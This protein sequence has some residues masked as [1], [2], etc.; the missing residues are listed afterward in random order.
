MVSAFMRGEKLSVN[1]LLLY[2]RLKERPLHIL[3]NKGLAM[4]LQGRYHSPC[5]FIGFRTIN[6]YHTNMLNKKVAQYQ[7]IQKQEFDKIE[8]QFII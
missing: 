7:Y 4:I 1:E 8:H 2:D 6:D 5:L 3:F